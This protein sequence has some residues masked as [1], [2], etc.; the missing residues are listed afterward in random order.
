M[1]TIDTLLLVLSVVVHLAGE[2]DGRTRLPSKV[3]NGP[4]DLKLQGRNSS[5]DFGDDPKAPEPP[6][7]GIEIGFDPGGATRFPVGE[8]VMLHG[9]Y[10]VDAPLLRQCKGNPG[11]GI[12]LTIIRTDKPFGKTTKLVTPTVEVELPPVEDAGVPDRTF[13]QKG[14]F[15]F[16]LARFFELDDEPG[17]YTIEAVIGPHFSH[18]LSF[19]L[20]P[21]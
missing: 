3:R 9:A 8:A 18:R 16:D 15:R 5:V 7:V 21:K 6:D 14:Q 10:R 2:Q 19:E 12:L 20:V 11:T 17:R 13:R 1:R 4:V